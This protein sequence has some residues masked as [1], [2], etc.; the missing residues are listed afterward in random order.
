VVPFPTQDLM[1]IEHQWGAIADRTR[2]HLVASDRCIIAVRRRL[3][4]LAKDL[5]NGIEPEEPFRIKGIR[6]E[7]PEPMRI[8]SG[9][10][11]DAE[12]IDKLLSSLNTTR[13]TAADQGE[14]DVMWAPSVEVDPESPTASPA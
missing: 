2:E 12:G 3:L 9:A 14:Y 1:M 4:K 11:I 13:L 5:A 7:L 6:Q 8:S 10:D